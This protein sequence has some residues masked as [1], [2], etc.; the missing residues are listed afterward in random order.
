MGVD[1]SATLVVGVKMSEVFHIDR[2]TQTITKYNPDTGE[3]YRKEI[4]KDKLIFFGR[5][6]EEPEEY[7]PGEWVSE[8]TKEAGAQL[9]AFDTGE[10]CRNNGSG[11]HAYDY[12]E[13]V[14]GLSVREGS[15]HRSY[16][17]HHILEASEDFIK[18]KIAQ[19]KER[20]GKLGYNGQVMVFVVNRL[21]C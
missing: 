3:P 17:D 12:N 14:V 18:V 6:I 7:H 1:Y 20:L 5:E 8:V 2:I 16:D 21:S 15:S 13:V 9:D 10:W 4:D 11:F 19:V